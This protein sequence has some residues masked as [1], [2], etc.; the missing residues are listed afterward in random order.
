MD[1][2]E[3]Y[4][5]VITTYMSEYASI[6]YSYGTTER[7]LGFRSGA[8]SL[9]FND[10]GLGRRSPGARLHH[11][12]GNYR[13]KNLDPSRWHGSGRCSNVAG[14]GNSQ[15]RYRASFLS[16]RTPSVD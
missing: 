3:R 2:L 11:P 13:R 1:T 6:P 7:H 10:R 16:T 5:N 15:G 8:R 4:R 9:P 12:R 14:G